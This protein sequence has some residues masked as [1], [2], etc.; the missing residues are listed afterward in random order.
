MEQRPHVQPPLSLISVRR[1][2]M[3]TSE[4]KAVGSAMFTLRPDES[5][6]KSLCLPTWSPLTESTVAL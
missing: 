1:I 4:T 2:T 3:A 6:V 5:L